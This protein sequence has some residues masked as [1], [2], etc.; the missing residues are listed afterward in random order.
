MQDIK[1]SKNMPLVSVVMPVYNYSAYLAKAIDS[2]LNQ[3]YQN[4]ELIIVNDASTDNSLTI[5]KEYQKQYPTKIKVID[6]QQNLNCGGDACAN[7]GLKIARGNYIARMDADDIAL[8]TRLEKQVRFLE[9]H[10]S[11]F[12]VGANAYT[13]NSNDEVTGE[14]NEPSTNQAI[15]VNYSIFHPL[16]HPACMYRRFLNDN[17]PFKYEIAY[18]SNNDYLTFFKLICAGYKFVNLKEKLLF[19]RVHPESNTFQN[20]K[21]IFFTT[22]RVR[23]LM[24]F[25]YG[26]RPNLK[27]LLSNF[28]EILLV[29]FL[30]EKS[31]V[32]LYFFVKGIKGEKSL[33]STSALSYGKI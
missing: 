16:I 1:R 20:V 10:H 18:K 9:K 3:T 22:F 33:M 11:I 5:I 28:A 23:L 27:A 31:I 26:Y 19:Y 25:R 17:K 4:F 29:T 32:S 8:P 6:L 21:Q 2:I 7:E 24:I 13:M 30:P 12:L 15:Y 14:K